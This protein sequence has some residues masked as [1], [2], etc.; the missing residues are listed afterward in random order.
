[1]GEYIGRIIR[2]VFNNV[3]TAAESTTGD[4]IGTIILLIIVGFIVC[5]IACAIGMAVAAVFRLFDVDTGGIA[6]CTVGV[7]VLMGRSPDKSTFESV[8][9]V[10]MVIAGIACIALAVVNSRIR[11][12]GKCTKWQFQGYA[13]FYGAFALSIFALSSKWYGMLPGNINKWCIYI[14]LIMSGLGA[15]NELFTAIGKEES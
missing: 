2:N 1:M 5:L 6:A 11:G 3:S 9:G 15:L 4:T 14:P 7:I 12:W 10:G 8:L 13:Y